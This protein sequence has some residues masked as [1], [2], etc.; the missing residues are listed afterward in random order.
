MFYE[1]ALI[2]LTA[3]QG[4]TGKYILHYEYFP[5]EVHILLVLVVSQFEDFVYFIQF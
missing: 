3:L 4:S 2:E 5:E 1:V